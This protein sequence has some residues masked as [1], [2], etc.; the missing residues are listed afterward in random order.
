MTYIGMGVPQEFL[1]WGWGVGK[2]SNIA[3]T[4]INKGAENKNC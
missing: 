3:G 2:A 4:K 1:L